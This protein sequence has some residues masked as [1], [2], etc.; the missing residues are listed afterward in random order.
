MGIPMFG[1]QNLNMQR[2]EKNG[3]AVALD[4]EDL[5]EESIINAVNKVVGDPTYV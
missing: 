1:D 2:A 5:T 3:F 4:Y